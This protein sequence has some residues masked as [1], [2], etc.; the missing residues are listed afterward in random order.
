M[1]LR[2]EEKG[3]RSLRA[4]ITRRNSLGMSVRGGYAEED[5]EASIAKATWVGANMQFT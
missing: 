4:C 5:R 3:G 2:C 1:V